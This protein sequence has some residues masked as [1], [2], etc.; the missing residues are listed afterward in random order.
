[1]PKVA[2]RGINTHYLTVGHGA[3]LVM[4]HGFLGNLAVW[5]LNMVPELRRHFRV[6]TYDLRG[7][8]YSDVTP[9][10]YSCDELAADLEALLDALDVHR[11]FLVGHS[12]GADICLNF[13]LAHPDR[14]EAVVA[15]EPGLAALVHER[16]SKDWDG[17]RYWVSKLEEVGLTVPADKRTD[18]DYLL[19][20]SLETPKFYGPARGLPR[21][22]EPLLN[23][24]R[25]TTLLADYEHVG[26]L[27][28]EAIPR[29]E[30]PT[31][32]VYGD[33]SHFLGTYA[34]LR[35]TLPRCEGVLLPGGE[36]FGPLEQPHLL[37]AHILRFFA[38]LAGI[39]LSES[40]ALP[41]AERVGS[42]L[43]G[44]VRSE[45]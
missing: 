36:H 35:R 7:H 31:L 23:L 41:A 32:L 3:D 8:G 26:Q 22:R 5:H 43:Y 24:I 42:E 27:T 45:A 29:I 25:N 10:G 37:T 28:L 11:A 21:R 9:G 19:T 15:L 33:K 4:V 16:K 2:A 1:M 6:T 13:A 44:W 38:P 17:W 40:P 12:Y 20:M 18:L 39:E 14:V 34:H 30:T